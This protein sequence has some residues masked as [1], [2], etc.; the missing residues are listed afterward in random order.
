MAVG[1]KN[2]YDEMSTKQDGHAQHRDLEQR[3]VV[4][5]RGGLILWFRFTSVILTERYVMDRGKEED[6]EIEEEVAKIQYTRAENVVSKLQT[7]Q[8]DVKT[9][10]GLVCA[11]RLF[12]PAVVCP[13]R[14]SSGCGGL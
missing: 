5:P 3:R 6:S 9:V 8:A 14:C 4:G 12:V 2:T 11:C 1:L 7:R 10:P 13:L